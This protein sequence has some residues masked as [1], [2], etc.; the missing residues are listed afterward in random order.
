MAQVRL[1]IDDAANRIT[2]KTMLEAEGHAV[3]TAGADVVIADAADKAVEA[4]RQAPALVLCP[5]SE[6][7]AAV[8]AMRKGVHGYILLPFQPG[9]AALMVERALQKPAQ[10]GE[11]PLMTLAEAEQQHI[12]KVLRRCN[13]NRSRAAK[14]LGIGRNTLWRKLGPRPKG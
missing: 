14:L 4:S 11:E 1:D 6:A 12:R 5:V 13:N 7:S 8:E 2:L 3:V 9:E 10:P